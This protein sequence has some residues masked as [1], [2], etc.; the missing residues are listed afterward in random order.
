MN[1]KDILEQLYSHFANYE[2][3]LNNTYV[4]DWESDFFA[5]SKSGYFIECEIKVSRSDFF[6]D[7][8]KDKHLLFKDV[9]AGKSHHVY[10]NPHY[11]SGDYL[12]VEKIA[13]M[14]LDRH[15]I[16]PTNQLI[17][18]NYTSFHKRNSG[19]PRL[20]KRYIVN[21]WAFNRI[22]I[23]YEEKSEWAKASSVKIKPM[24][25]IKIP[26]QFYY[27]VPEGLVNLEEV[28]KYAGLIYVKAPYPCQCKV[29]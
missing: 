18:R 14:A 10:R 8:K 5:K 16:D 12:G 11:A 15:R 20:T 23:R 1:A 2:Y 6:V 4:F 22:S 3:K 28:P 24:N 29:Y 27:V 26:H 13:Y 9:V 7:F 19:D 17:E 25:E 21:D